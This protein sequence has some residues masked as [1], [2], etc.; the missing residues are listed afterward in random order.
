[1]IIS[2]YGVKLIR[3]KQEH[4]ELIRYWRNSTK[5]RSVMEY[6]EFITQKMQ[7]KWFSSLQFLHDFYFV[8]EYEG[9]LVGLIHASDVNWKDRSAQSGL[10]IWEDSYHGSPVPIMASVN[11]LDV[12]F[13]VLD[14]MEF[15]AK[16]K[17]DN[18]NALTYNR[19]SAR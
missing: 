13:D 17:H 12:F 18:F 15:N 19:N 4:L 2:R 1:M 6:Q 5:I 9:I 11:M 10:F 16:V 7:L 8:I 3:L 14:L